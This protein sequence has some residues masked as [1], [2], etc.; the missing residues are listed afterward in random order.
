M[1]C[2]SPS[3]P[4]K[5]VVFVKPSQIGGTECLLNSI[6]YYIHYSPASILAV[7][8]T[9]ELG[10]R[11][12][13]QR[14]QSM[15]DESPALSERVK[16]PRD[17]DSGNAILA[18]EFPGG[19]CMITGSNSASG[20]R[21]MPIRFL[22]MDEIDSF[23]GDV[24]QEGDPV[25]VAEK[26]T[27]TFRNRKIF[28]LSTP[29]IKHFSRIESEY[30]NSTKHRY[31]VP[32]PFCNT[33]Q[34]LE[35]SGITY[36]KEKPKDV[37]YKCKHCGELISESY[38]TEM[39]AR[40][41]WIAEFP[42][43]ETWGFHLN[44]LYSPY[45]W[46]YWEELVKEW[47]EAQEDTSLLKVFVNHRLAEAW[48][49]AIEKIDE[50]S[51]Y[52]NREHYDSIPLGVAFLAAGIDT[53]DD[54]LEI[55]VYGFGQ[56]YEAWLIEHHIIHSDTSLVSTWDLL[57]N[58]FTKSWEDEFGNVYNIVCA[59]I[60]SRG[61]RTTEVYQYCKKRIQR[62]IYCIAGV[63]GQGQPMVKRPT[64]SNKGRV[65]LYNV[66]SDTIKDGVLAKLRTGKLH[67][68]DTVD[69]E[70]C[71]QLTAEAPKPVKKKGYTKREYVQLRD[72]NE[73]IDCAVYA[74]AACFILNPQFDAILKHLHKDK[75]LPKPAEQPIL[76]T[77]K[78]EPKP[79]EN[80]LVESRPIENILVE[81]RPVRKFKQPIRPRQ[82]WALRGYNW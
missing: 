65:P 3:H 41:E 61:H 45:G 8:P 13:K 76:A 55:S 74:H 25:S 53:Q 60:D 28:L 63:G 48:E 16:P 19:I 47:I 68:R 36:S 17:R 14:L 62:R 64:A 54:R 75:P 39:L 66:G 22:L 5:R 4:A 73:A 1:D 49:E 27:Q 43:N 31:H 33:K 67:I 44:S 34:T 32:C 57:D 37:K 26:R 59:A 79:I 29:T 18:K 42:D 38:K 10:Q 81:S 50:L 2:L 30:N 7:Y 70:F 24:E 20:L 6:G 52:S 82:S 40:G 71:K 35:W 72:R 46:L 15:I 21:S 23:P 78:E 56:H 12:S 58:Y 69:L 11:W 9:V 77:P 80:I 51:V